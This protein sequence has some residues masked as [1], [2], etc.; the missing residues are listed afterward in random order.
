M[1]RSFLTIK[2][3]GGEIM[4]ARIICMKLFLQSRNA[5]LNVINQTGRAFEVVQ[6]SKNE[7]LKV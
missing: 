7:S 2:P 1:V 4:V 5:S 6:S 3:P